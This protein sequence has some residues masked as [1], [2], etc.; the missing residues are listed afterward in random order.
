MRTDPSRSAMRDRSGTWVGCCRPERPQGQSCPAGGSGAL[1]QQA[2]LARRAPEPLDAF[3]PL[4]SH[5][6]LFP[7]NEDEPPQPRAT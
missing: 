7:M 4:G 1:R 2:R 3:Y 5:E 6:L